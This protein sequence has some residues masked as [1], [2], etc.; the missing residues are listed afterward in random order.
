MSDSLGGWLRRQRQ[1]RGVHLAVLAGALKV[2]LQK[3]ESLE[4]D[5]LEDLP[6]AAFVRSLVLSL[7]RQLQLDPEP[8][9]HLLPPVD[10]EKLERLGKGLNAPFHERLGYPSLSAPLRSAGR[11]R[12][13]SILISAAF[14]VLIAA[15][16][17][18]FYP[19][20]RVSQTA[21]ALVSPALA[22]ANS[23]EKPHEK[24]LGRSQVFSPPSGG[25]AQSDRSGASLKAAPALPTAL[26]IQAREAAMVEVSDAQGQIL[27]ARELATGEEVELDGTPPIR[28]KLSNVSAAQVLLRGQPV[29]LSAYAPGQSAEL[30]L[31]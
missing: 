3:L 23:V 9:V 26:H 18:Y 28:V 4:A 14:L 10:F 22:L 25:L 19:G 5:R 13:F 30:E 1:A 27:L 6:D 20:R 8:I 24:T 17:V 12:A 11:G 16:A 7:C 31:R 15:A 21:A 2:P 29:D